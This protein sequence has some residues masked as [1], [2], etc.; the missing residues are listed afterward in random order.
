[1]TI[2]GRIEWG[3]VDVDVKTQQ[4]NRERHA[5]VVSS[6]RWWARRPHAVVGAILDAARSQFAEDKFPVSD[7]FSGGGTV[8]FE[9]TKRGLPVY[10]QDLYP[11][12]T[13]ALASALEPTEPEHLAEAGRA[14]LERL[15]PYRRLYWREEGPDTYE[16]T[17]IIRVRIISCSHC[18]SPV[19]LFPEPPISLA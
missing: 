8:A 5:P 11:W 7:P 10:A 14:L 19:Y 9:A 17:H 6:F 13:Y 1:M 2:L 12:P 15:T 4:A 3:K 18:N 16:V